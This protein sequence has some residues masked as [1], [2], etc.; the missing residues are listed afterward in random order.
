MS[1]LLPNY[2][3]A[4]REFVSGKGGYLVDT[5]GKQYLD[6]SSGIGVANLGYD[7]PKVKQAIARQLDALWHTPNLYQN[8]LQEKVASQLIGTQNYQAFFCNSGTEANEAALKLIRKASGKEKI[9]TF[10]NS[11]HG[12]TFGS[13]SA[14]GQDKIHSGFGKIVP[15]FVYLPYNELSA[16]EAAIDE[17]VGGVLLELIQG[18]G[19]VLPAD[20][21]WIEGVAKICRTKNI[22]LAVDEVQTGIGR[23]GTLFLTEQYEVE[24]DIITLAKGLGNGVP[25]GALL[26]TK[27]L[28]TFFGPGTH[29]STFGGNL[30]A[31]SAA[32]AVLSVIAEPDFLND[33]KRK[34]DV[35]RALLEE[36]LLSMENVVAIRGIGFMLGIEVNV[37]PTEVVEKMAK[38][39]VIAL[40]AGQTV[41]RLLPPLTLSVAQLKSGVALLKESL[42]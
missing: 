3:R 24:P 31:M 14:T 5:E 32:S 23:T 17:E 42:D 34:G 19:G 30:L 36:E 4:N 37:S 33:V 22:I 9:I 27:E 6:F 1:Y 7:H 13:M 20:K 41:I 10:K 29:G 38:K 28:A 35:L 2:Q 39:G 8:S 11:F 12:R 21:A 18:E 16:F 26:A 40:T 15:G 25:V